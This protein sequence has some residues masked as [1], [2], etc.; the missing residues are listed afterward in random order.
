MSTLPPAS[1]P[2][3]LEPTRWLDADQAVDHLVAQCMRDSGFAPEA[4][5]W[6]AFA[7]RFARVQARVVPEQRFAFAT[8]LDGRLVEMGLAPWSIARRLTADGLPGGTNVPA[9]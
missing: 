9:S 8:R 3:A 7:T 6:A 1:F 5:F 2:P 4:D